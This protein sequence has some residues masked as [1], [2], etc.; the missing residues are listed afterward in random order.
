MKICIVLSTRPE[1]IKLSPV[2]QI[3]KEKKVNYYLINTG[4]HTLK[5]MSKVFFDL[6][7]IGGKIFNIKSKKKN[8][9]Y[10]FFKHNS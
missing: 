4:Q 9:K 2:I 5:K 8:T 7:K 6:F 3:L 10:F 1:I